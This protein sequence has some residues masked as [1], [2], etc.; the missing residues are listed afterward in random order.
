M[1]KPELLFKDNHLPLEVPDSKGYVEGYASV[2]DVIDSQKQVVD[3][4]AFMK[5]LADP[6]KI[7]FLWQH[8]YKRPIG[9]LVKLWEDDRGLK[10]QARYNLKT[11]WGKD[12]YEA[13]VNGDIDG[14][15]IGYTMLNGKSF[16]D[17]D[18]VDHLADVGLMEIS[19]VTFPSNTEAVNT[20]VKST[21]VEEKT[22]IPPGKSGRVLSAKNQSD[23]QDAHDHLGN[24][25]KLLGGVLGKVSDKTD[26]SADGAAEKRA[27]DDEEL[28]IKLTELINLLRK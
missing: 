26:E 13:A 22:V 11:S 28:K 7:K 5:A 8:D 23:L 9:K 3:R 14:N 12:A 15:S 21:G 25:H 18:G 24:A 1:S 16:K 4:G 17:D 2:Y 6:K 10:Y 20:D 19:N 27:S